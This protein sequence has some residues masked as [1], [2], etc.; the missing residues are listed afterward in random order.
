M[1]CSALNQDEVEQLVNTA[2]KAFRER[3][4]RALDEDTRAWLVAHGIEAARRATRWELNLLCSALSQ[5]EREQ[6]AV[7]R[8][9]V[10]AERLARG[11]P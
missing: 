8:H 1:L 5:E 9:R 6:L 7:A 10:Q 2:R 11:K 3:A 4:E